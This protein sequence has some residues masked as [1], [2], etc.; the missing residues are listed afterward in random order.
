MD[1]VFIKGLELSTLIGVY[2]FERLAKQRII[3]D[4][5]LQV[6]LSIAGKSDDVF[7]TVDYGKIAQCL[8]DIC[9][10]A[11]YTLLEALAHEMTTTILREYAVNK[12]R[13][14]LNKPDILENV[15]QVG[16]ITERSRAKQTIQ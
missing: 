6:D 4:V 3:V 11:T 14:T 16:I 2:D 5:E 12:V 10:N 1:T 9:E 15:E 7:D 8:S 13:L